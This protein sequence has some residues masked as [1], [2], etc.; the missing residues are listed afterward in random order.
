MRKD[1]YIDTTT[2]PS[3]TTE[4]KTHIRHHIRNIL[5]EPTFVPVSKDTKGVTEFYINNHLRHHF[6]MTPDPTVYPV[7][8]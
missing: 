3:L 8:T 5:K 1:L 6:K 4:T 7:R 2:Y